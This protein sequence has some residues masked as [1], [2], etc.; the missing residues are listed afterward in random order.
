MPNIFPGFGKA[1]Q[2]YLATPGIFLGIG[3]A[4]VVES[5]PARTWRAFAMHCRVDGARRSISA[6]CSKHGRVRG[7]F[8][9][10]GVPCLAHA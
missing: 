5:V 10:F 1:R 3:G 7:V 4:F 8:D 2:P 9:R 6:A